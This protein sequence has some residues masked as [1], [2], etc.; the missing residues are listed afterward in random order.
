M[1]Q[2][3]SLVRFLKST[4]QVDPAYWDV[5]GL[6]TCRYDGPSWFYGDESRYDVLVIDHII[7]NCVEGQEIEEL[8]DETG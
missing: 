6:V 1:I 8:D 5:I 4:D 7:T 2:V 3:G